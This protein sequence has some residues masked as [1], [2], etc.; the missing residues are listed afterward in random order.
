MIRPAAV[1][2]G[3][4]LLAAPALAAAGVDVTIDVRQHA[5]PDTTGR[6][7][8][9]TGRIANGTAGETVEVLAKDC[10][11]VHRFYR[12]VAGTKT[13]AGGA[14]RIVTNRAPDY[15]QLPANAYLR[16]RWNGKLSS[17]VLVRVPAIV[18]IYWRPR[19]RTLDVAIANGATGQS[20]RR[21]FVELQRKVEASDQWVRV[22]RA[23]LGPGAFE[24]GAG[25]VFR[26]RFRVPGRGLTL[27]VTLPDASGAPCFSASASESFE[28]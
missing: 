21:R 11:P 3:A 25:T 5:V 27:R 14:Y 8:E 28:S 9:V 24:R 6:E 4:A 10:G 13:A 19:A 18:S 12:V 23:R 2:V 22:R 20:L 15:H 1:A 17:P 16:A 26:A 7:I